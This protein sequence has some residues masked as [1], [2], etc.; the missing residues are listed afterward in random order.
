[1]NLKIGET[2]LVIFILKKAIA[3]NICAI[4]T[5]TPPTRTIRRPAPIR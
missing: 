5:N 4:K 1:M 3:N 2:Y